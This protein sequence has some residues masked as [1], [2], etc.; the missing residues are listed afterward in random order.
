MKRALVGIRDGPGTGKDGDRGGFN[1]N[2]GGKE[3]GSTHR[4]QTPVYPSLPS[5]PSCSRR[6][7]EGPMSHRQPPAETSSIPRQPL[8]GASSHSTRELFLCHLHAASPPQALLTAQHGVHFLSA[9]S[10]THPSLSY[11]LSPFRVPRTVLRLWDT[12]GAR[13]GLPSHGVGVLLGPTGPNSGHA[14]THTH[15][16]I[17][18][19]TH[20]V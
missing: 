8:P 1:R 13:Q 4:A 9:P 12:R 18:T 20:T 14:R 2:H 17:H 16:H 7:W 5:A 15:T 10:L 11:L 3:G 19:H 6:H